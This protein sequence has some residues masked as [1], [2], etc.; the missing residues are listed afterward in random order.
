M[1]RLY[2]SFVFLLFSALFFFCWQ[3]V[4]AVSDSVLISQVR[5][6]D[7]NSAKNEFVEMYNNTTSDIDIT[8]WCLQYVSTGGSQNKMACVSPKVSG[9]KVFLPTHAFLLMISNDYVSTTPPV[10]GD[11]SFSATLSGTGGYIRLLDGVGTEVDKVGWGMA[12]SEQ[13]LAVI[14]VNNFVLKRKATDKGVLQDTDNYYNDFTVAEA[15][16]LIYGQ[17]YEVPDACANLDGFQDAAP[18]GYEPDGANC[19]SLTLDVCANIDGIQA[20]LPEGMEVSDND[21]TQSDKCL[22]IPGVQSVLPAYFV[23]PND[24]GQCESQILP[25]RVS[26][27]LP[28]AV[29][30]DT[31]NEFIEVYNPNNS[32]VDLSHY[33]FYVGPNYEKN[34][35]F[36]D[37]AVVEAGRYKVFYNNSIKFSLLNTSGSVRLQSADGYLTNETATYNDPDEGSAW[38]YIDSVWQYTDQITPGEANLPSLLG[39]E[40]IVVS[41]LRA[42]AANQYRSP[43][44]NRCRLIVSSSSATLMPCR[45]GQYRSE[46]TNRC[47]NIASD[48]N[49]SLPCAEDQ[50]RNP[51]TNRCRSMKK[52]TTAELVSCKPGQERNPATNRCRNAVT[53]PV[54]SYAPEQVNVS[55]NN[56]YIWWSVAGAGTLAAGYGLWEWRQEFV[57]LLRKLKALLSRHK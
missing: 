21:C 30:A 24:D 10:L 54:T 41:S 28:N 16:P 4:G 12:S 7:V 44:T 11:V 14:P 22:N 34:Y 31:D 36:P 23:S 51:A 2:I 40:E 38:A 1:K 47:R 25:L 52:S 27:L 45:D 13:N 33:V 42:C 35:S 48:V 6:G 53:M 39:S 46:E 19:R 26:E 20:T 50:E 56:G 37:G 57:K 55:S 9:A 43:E 17:I 8:N 32:D 15:S 5:L 49:S 3:R 18:D 29:G